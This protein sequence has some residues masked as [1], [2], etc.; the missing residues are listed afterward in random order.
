MLLE[1]RL[2]AVCDPLPAEAD[3][4]LREEDSDESRVF[5]FV[6]LSATSAVLP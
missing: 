5:P 3:P 1:S 6:V 2:I 4:F